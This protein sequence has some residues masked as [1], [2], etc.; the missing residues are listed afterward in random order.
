MISFILYTIFILHLSCASF[1]KINKLD[2]LIGFEVENI[3]F[4]KFMIV[5][6]S[7]STVIIYPLPIIA[8]YSIILYIF[9]YVDD[10]PTGQKNNSSKR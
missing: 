9:A 1:D 5:V 2:G 8:L 6:I 10:F 4:F 7:L 3:I